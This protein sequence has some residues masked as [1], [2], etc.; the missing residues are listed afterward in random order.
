LSCNIFLPSILIWIGRDSI[1]SIRV[2]R[3]DRWSIQTVFVLLLGSTDAASA[4]GGCK[5]SGLRKFDSLIF[6]ETC[7]RLADGFPLAVTVCPPPN[8]G[9]LFLMPWERIDG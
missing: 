8:F 7:G 3:R 2:W 1:L 5:V 6:S 4:W 9:G